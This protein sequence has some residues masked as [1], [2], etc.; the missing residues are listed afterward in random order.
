VL[1]VDGAPTIAFQG[2]VEEEIAQL[3]V[4][5]VA[6]FLEAM[7]IEEPASHRLVRTCYYALDV[8]AFFTVGEDECRAWTTNRGDTAPVAAGRIHSDLERGFIRAESFTYDDLRR[9]G[10]VQAVKDAGLFKLEGKTHVV[11]DGEILN[12]RFNV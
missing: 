10:T 6:E 9:L 7:G 12:I 3:P 8:I 4:E 1:L 5:E 11:Q 2:K